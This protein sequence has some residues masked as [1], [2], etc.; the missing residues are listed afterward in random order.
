MHNTTRANLLSF[1]HFLLTLLFQP[2]ALTH[3]YLFPKRYNTSQHDHTKAP[4][5]SPL[6]QHITTHTTAQTPTALQCFLYSSEPRPAPPI[7][8]HEPLSLILL[9]PGTR[10]R[11]QL[12]VSSFTLSLSLIVFVIVLVS[13]A[14][15]HNSIIITFINTDFS[16]TCTFISLFLQQTVYHYYYYTYIHLTRPTF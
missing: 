12:R 1:F 14:Y 7:L 5:H 4:T 10:L 3:N 13:F 6:Q 8:A 11:G 2:P 15:K 9:R 16:R